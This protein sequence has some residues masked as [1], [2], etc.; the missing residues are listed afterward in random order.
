MA[1]PLS[2]VRAADGSRGTRSL[3]GIL[4]DAKRMA[5]LIAAFGRGRSYMDGSDE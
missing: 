1:N 5:R 4:P 2:P 3:P